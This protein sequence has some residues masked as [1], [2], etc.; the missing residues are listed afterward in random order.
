VGRSVRLPNPLNASTDAGLS[1]PVSYLRDGVLVSAIGRQ[2]WIKPWRENP[3]I[4]KYA[5]ADLAAWVFQSTF[6]LSTAA[7]ASPT[8]NLSP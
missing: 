1:C 2:L 8:L 6:R 4:F 5:A 3:D 7:V